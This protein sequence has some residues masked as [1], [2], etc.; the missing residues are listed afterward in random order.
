MTRR[1]SR[2]VAQE[3]GVPGLS[4]PYRMGF[5]LMAAREEADRQDPSGGKTTALRKRIEPLKERY[6]SS[7]NEKPILD[8]LDNILGKGWKP[9]ERWAARIAE[10]TE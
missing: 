1:K 10:E 3:T 5:I 9:S 8:A 2:K 7:R 6:L 4:W